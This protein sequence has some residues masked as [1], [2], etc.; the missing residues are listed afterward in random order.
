[1]AEQNVTN[2][3]AGFKEAVCIDAGRVY[4]S[5]SDKD[6]LEDLQVYFTATEQAKIDRALTVKAKSVEVLNVCLEVEPIPFNRG[7]YSVRWFWPFSGICRKIFPSGNES[8]CFR[9]YPDWKLHK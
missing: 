6:C 5:C 7:F 3:A 9:S 4:D 2:G 8:L 1:M